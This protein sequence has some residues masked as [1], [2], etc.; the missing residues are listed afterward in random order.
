MPTRRLKLRVRLPAYQYP[1]T[2][3]K[4][5]IRKAVIKRARGRVRYRD[6][7]QLE[8][9]VRLYLEK[10]QLEKVDIDNQLKLVLDALQGQ[11]GGG[12]KKRARS[13]RVIPNDS[14]VYRV[15]AEKSLPP[16]QADGMGHLTIQRY[17]GTRSRSSG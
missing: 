12:G 3:W 6:D 14:Q 10:E 15:T 11:V 4:Q 8:V 5:A 13:K 9:E 16:K 1:P 2:D 17:R 7:D